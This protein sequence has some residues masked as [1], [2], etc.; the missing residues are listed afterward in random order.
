MLGSCGSDGVGG[1]SSW[2]FGGG[3]F[4]V[5]LHEFGEIELGLLEDLYFP[6]HA[7]VVEWEYFA[8][9]LL[10]LLANILFNPRD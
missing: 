2:L 1:S 5:K 9:L 3:L 7:V 6:Y 10:N 4:F 8:A